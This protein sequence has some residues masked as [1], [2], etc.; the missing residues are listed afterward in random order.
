MRLYRYL[1]ISNEL[2][3]NTNGLG[4]IKPTNYNYR[5]VGY[6]ELISVNNPVFYLQVD[7]YKEKLWFMGYE[8][9]NITLFDKD[10]YRYTALVLIDEDDIERIRDVQSKTTGGSWST[11]NDNKVDNKTDES[12]TFSGIDDELLDELVEHLYV[13]N[14]EDEN[15]DLEIKQGV[16]MLKNLNNK[17][18]LRTGGN[19][20]IYLSKRYIRLDDVITGKDIN[21][22]WIKSYH[23]GHIFDYRRKALVLTETDDE[24]KEQKEFEKKSGIVRG[25]YI[26]TNLND[27]SRSIQ[28]DDLGNKLKINSV[29]A[30]LVIDREQELIDLYNNLTSNIYWNTIT[31]KSNSSEK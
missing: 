17:S 7:A 9:N 31:S 16:G 20:S 8:Y 3:E 14:S 13:E 22:S 11:D 1:L 25:K 27:A 29:S 15:T 12:R 30:V 19:L 5:G 28:G 21:K 23:I 18:K 4:L 6:S 10:K 2:I 26:T 24:L